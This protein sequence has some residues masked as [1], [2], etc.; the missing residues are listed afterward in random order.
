MSNY[1][2]LNPEDEALQK[3]VGDALVFEFYLFKFYMNANVL[4][5]RQLLN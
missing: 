5:I 1:G 3:T 4:E 2:R